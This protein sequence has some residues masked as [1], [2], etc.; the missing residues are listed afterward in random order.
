MLRVLTSATFLDR[1]SYGKRKRLLHVHKERTPYLLIWVPEAASRAGNWLIPILIS[2]NYTCR[3]EKESCEGGISGISNFTERSS[4]SMFKGD[5]QKMSFLESWS[6]PLVCGPEVPRATT[7]HRNW[8]QGRKLGKFQLGNASLGT[9]FRG[10]MHWKGRYPNIPDLSSTFDIFQ[11]RSFSFTQFRSCHATGRRSGLLPVR[12]CASW[13]KLE[14]ETHSFHRFLSFDCW[15][16]FA[17]R[18][19]IVRWWNGDWF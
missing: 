10:S 4:L 9:E 12:R 16:W 14:D 15:T 3:E 7:W 2:V 11:F 5:I 18:F 1:T 19:T 13:Y 17:K 8:Y 6:P